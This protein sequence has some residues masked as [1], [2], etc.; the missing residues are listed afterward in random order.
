M[1]SGEQRA[2]SS[3]LQ[4][5]YHLSTFIT[6]THLAKDFRLVNDKLNLLQK[7]DLAIHQLNFCL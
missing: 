5:V 4:E 2:V 1:R 3:D 6:Y 7:S